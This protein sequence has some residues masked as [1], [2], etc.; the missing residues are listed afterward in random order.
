MNSSASRIKIVHQQ[1]EKLIEEIALLKNDKNEMINT[2]LALV[3]EIDDQKRE[4][5]DLNQKMQT[6]KLAKSIRGD[7][8]PQE[9]K[10]LKRKINEYIKEI[11]RCIALLNH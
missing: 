2:N 11:D 10:E 7:D 3:K 4:L 6:L 9:T 8:K 5:E 1:V